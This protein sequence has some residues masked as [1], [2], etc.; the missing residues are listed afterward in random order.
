MRA[1]VLIALALVAGNASADDWRHK[2]DPWVLRNAEAQHRVEFLVMLEAQAD[3]RDAAQLRTKVERGTLVYQ[4]AAEVAQRTQPPVIAAIT[5]AG[6]PHRSFRIVNAILVEGD[7]RLVEALASRADVR[8]V[9]A[10]PRV[11]LREPA[12]APDRAHIERIEPNIIQTRAPEQYWAAGFTGQGI[13]VANADSGVQWTHPALRPHYLGIRPGG[14]SHDYHWHDAIHSCGGVC[15]AD[16]PAPCDD[17]DHGTMT[18]GVIVGDDGQGNQ[19]GMAPG[20]RWIACRNMDQGVGTPATYI[21][22]FDFFL[23]P[24]DLNGQNPRPERAPDVVSN[25]W[26]CTIE[27]GCVNPLILRRVVETLRAAGIFVVAS[28]GNSGNACGSVE[29]P[30]AIYDASYTVGAVNI[31]GEVEGFS[32]RGPVIVDGS[33]RLKPDVV[34][35]GDNIR[36][37]LRGG[38]YASASGTSLSGPHV[39]GLAA[40]ML[41][42]DGGFAGNLDAIE[43]WINTHAQGLPTSEICGAF[44]GSRLPNTTYGH[45]IIRAALPAPGEAC[46]LPISGTAMGLSSGAVRCTDESTGASA[47][48]PLVAT[49]FDCDD[50]GL[51]TTPGDDIL[52]TVSSPA[53]AG[54]FTGNVIGMTPARAVCHNRTSGQ[55]VVARLTQRNRS[56]DCSANGFVAALGD[57]VLI[58]VSGTA[59]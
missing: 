41:S 54:T 15:G 58:K 22:C 18:M 17:D 57:P 20:A 9:F 35:P 45:G 44:D 16:S 21:E 7:L 52:L 5:A 36:T 19:I 50:A 6:A 53:F 12:P 56:W 51:A 28:A 24:T 23:A 48:S 47:T 59:D 8:H 38:G 10:N 37:S 13:V 39:A 46:D 34:A 11:A 3:L 1:Y 25:S 33:Y 32:S 2:V 40:L 14:A 55:T 42:A 26:I 29:S 27:E 49:T 30:P 43:S 4:R 31:F